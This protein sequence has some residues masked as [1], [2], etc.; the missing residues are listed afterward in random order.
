MSENAFSRY[1][2]SALPW[3]PAWPVEIDLHLHT[4]VSDGTLTPAQLI[5]LVGST[6]LKTIAITDHDTTSGMEEALNAVKKYPRGNISLRFVLTKICIVQ[7]K[8]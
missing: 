4:N 7:S 3:G 1:E 5:K 8:I 2:P 6:N